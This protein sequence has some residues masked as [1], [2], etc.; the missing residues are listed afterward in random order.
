MKFKSNETPKSSEV[1]KEEITTPVEEKQICEEMLELQQLANLA[2]MH[3]DVAI[4]SLNHTKELIDDL[5][6][7]ISTWKI[8][9]EEN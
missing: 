1:T 9:S 6:N 8:Q 2:T 4:R 5:L 7:Y 3:L